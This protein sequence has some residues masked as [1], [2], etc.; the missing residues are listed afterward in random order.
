[1]DNLSKALTYGVSAL[2]FVI[3]LSIAIMSYTNIMGF[4]DSIL[5]TSERHD[6]GVEGIQTVLSISDNETAIV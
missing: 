2:L 6:H 4:V 3:A 5:T 1:M